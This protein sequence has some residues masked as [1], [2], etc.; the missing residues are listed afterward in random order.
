MPVGVV[1]NLFY[2]VVPIGISLLLFVESDGLVEF[3]R[4]GI[5]SLFSVFVCFKKMNSAFWILYCEF[6]EMLRFSPGIVSKFDDSL[7]SLMA[8]RRLL[9]CC[10]MN[11]VLESLNHP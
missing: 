3:C 4:M 6:F 1:S 2:V 11:L 9:L 8:V 7:Q 10:S 5:Y